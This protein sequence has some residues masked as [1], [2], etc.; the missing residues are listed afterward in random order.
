MKSKFLIMTMLIVF[1]QPSLANVEA[2]SFTGT[3]KTT[4]CTFSKAKTVT[5]TLVDSVLKL[6]FN[7]DKT[8][9]EIFTESMSS[10]FESVQVLTESFAITNLFFIKL[11]TATGSPVSKTKI[12]RSVT[13]NQIRIN[14]IN[15]ERNSTSE[16]FLYRK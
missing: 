16:C 13:G 10:E 4:D 6:E 7:G 15:Y 5:I 14:S 11:D 8:R 9:K 12:T 3:F 1:S 2:E